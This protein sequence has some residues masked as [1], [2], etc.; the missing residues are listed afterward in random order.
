MLQQRQDRAVVDQNIYRPS[1]LLSTVFKFKIYG[2][3]QE[4]EFKKAPNQAEYFQIL[5]RTVKILTCS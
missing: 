5:E 2:F 1:L 4:N 3:L